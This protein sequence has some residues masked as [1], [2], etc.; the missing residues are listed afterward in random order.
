L[1]IGATDTPSS[2]SCSTPSRAVPL[3][4]RT[5]KMGL[6]AREMGLVLGALV[7]W[8]AGIRPASWFAEHLDDANSGSAE[9]QPSA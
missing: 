8:Q 9:A 3:Y 2:A 5:R 6:I 4:L 7:E 1:T